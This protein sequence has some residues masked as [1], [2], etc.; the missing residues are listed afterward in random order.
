[1]SWLGIVSGRPLAGERMLLAESIR[2]EA[3]IW[4][5]TDS[6]TWT[7]I[8]SPSK[9]ALKAAHTSGW[10]WMALPSTRIGSK[11]WMPSRCSV[12]ARLRKIGCSLDDF[13]EEVPDLGT[14]LFVPFAGDLDARDE[15]FLFQLVENERLEELEGHLLGQAALVELELGADDDDRPARVIDALAEQVLA[16]P[17]LLAPERFAEGLERAA[18]GP[19]MDPAAL[20]VVEQ[21]VHRFLEHP[22]FVA[23]DQLGGAQL[24]ELFQPVVAVDDP[25]VEVVEVRRGEPPAVQTDQGPQVGRDDRDDVQDHPF[26]PV[27]GF[28]QGFENPQPLG[29]PEAA[30][31]GRFLL[32]RLAQAFGFLLDVDPLEQ[33]LDGLRPDGRLELVAVFFPGFLVFFLAQELFFL[34]RGVAGIEDDVG[35]EI[36]D[37]FEVLDRE[38]HD[39]ADAARGGFEEPDMGH[40]RGQLDVAHPFPPDLALGHFDAAA[41]ADDAAVFHPFVLAAEAFVIVDRAENLGAEEAVFFRLERP[42]VDGLGF[43]H[44]APGPALDLFRRGDRDADPVEILAGLAA[45]RLFDVHQRSPLRMPV[46]SRPRTVVISCL[47][48]LPSSTLRQRLCNSRIRTLTDSGSPGVNSRS[49]LTMAS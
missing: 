37:L 46:A 48:S 34:E 28:L 47:S 45:Q 24:D 7:A 31:L 17:A 40:G 30:L 29:I 3:S 4:A 12:G 5:S 44:L 15:P 6:G 18:V 20:A 43:G 9:S 13:L 33:D 22:L 49:P 35:L 21:R 10:I 25:A 16:E 19:Q 11:A 27:A 41:L 36:E 42:V 8:W 23:D 1:M 39:Q 32:H 14:F 26:R 38:V 2:V